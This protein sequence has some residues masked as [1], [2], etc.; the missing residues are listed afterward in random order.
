MQLES[1]SRPVTD[2]QSCCRINQDRWNVQS[3]DPLHSPVAESRTDIRIAGEWSAARRQ[4]ARGCCPFET[5]ISSY[6]DLALEP[7]RRAGQF[8]QT[9]KVDVSYGKGV[10]SSLQQ[11][12]DRVFLPLTG[13]VSTDWFRESRKRNGSEKCF[14]SDSRTICFVFSSNLK[15]TH[16]HDRKTRLDRKYVAK[17][18]VGLFSLNRFDIAYLQYHLV[19][20]G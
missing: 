16:F 17:N 6:L 11:F 13:A 15:N 10:I 5:S 1:I 19:R 2:K 3:V 12:Q 14:S 20:T 9:T 18:V 4:F 8:V 7:V